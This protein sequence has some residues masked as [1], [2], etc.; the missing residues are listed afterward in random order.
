M[1][2]DESGAGAGMAAAAEALASVVAILP[3]EAQLLGQ[4]RMWRCGQKSRG[5]MKRAERSSCGAGW[6]SDRYSCAAKY[7]LHTIHMCWVRS[8]GRAGVVVVL[9]RGVGSGPVQAAWQSDV[10]G[11][12]VKTL[13][14]G[15][16]AHLPEVDAKPASLDGAARPREPTLPSAA[17]VLCSHHI[18]NGVCV[19]WLGQEVQCHWFTTLVKLFC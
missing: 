10:V 19:C 18:A 5:C 12:G 6:A 9:C 4:A 7:V 1:D 15:R 14:R 2:A 16:V 17:V 8:E 11:R 3:Y 13:R